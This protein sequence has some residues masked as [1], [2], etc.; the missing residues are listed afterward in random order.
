MHCNSVQ[1]RTRLG[2]SSHFH[3]GVVPHNCVWV[4]STKAPLRGQNVDATQIR[5][6]DYCGEWR[7]REDDSNTRK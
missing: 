5:Q 7:R 2:F 4:P 6:E 3:K 1:A